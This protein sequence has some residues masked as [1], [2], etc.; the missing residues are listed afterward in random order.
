MVLIASLLG[1]LKQQWIVD[2]P[3][4]QLV[5]VVFVISY[6]MIIVNNCFYYCFLWCYFYLYCFCFSSYNYKIFYYYYFLYFFTIIIVIII[7]KVSPLEK[8]RHIILQLYRVGEM[9]V[10]CFFVNLLLFLL[11]ILFLLILFLSILILFLL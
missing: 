8:Q 1:I 2:F 10:C 5:V 9:V 11:L 7:K 3:H 4:M 6:F